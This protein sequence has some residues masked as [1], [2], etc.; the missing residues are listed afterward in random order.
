[1]PPRPGPAA[2]AQAT[3]PPLATGKFCA[4]PKLAVTARVRGGRT[5]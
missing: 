5:N 2:P 3:D 1:V 4:T